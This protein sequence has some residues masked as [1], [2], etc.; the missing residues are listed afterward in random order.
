MVSRDL[1]RKIAQM[2][3]VGF[4]EAEVRGDTPVVRVM[5]DFGV[6]GVILYNIDLK[7]FVDA[8]KTNPDLNRIDGARMCPKNIRSPQQLKALTLDLQSFSAE[9]ILIA[10]DQEGGM[11]SR[12]SPAAGY[13]PRESHEELGKRDDLS[14]TSKIAAGIADDLAA[15]G[16]NLN[17]A[18]VVDLSINP[19]SPLFRNGRCF[20]SDP[21]VVFR[22]AMEF[23]LAHSQRGIRTCLKHFPGKGSAGKD[24]HFDLPDITSVYREEEL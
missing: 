2:I 24:T 1:K 20:G 16:I 4:P 10:A 3:M 18:P 21:D 15:G 7:C 11:V 14:F 9:P 23:I 13:P 17:L 8:Q 5:K 22:H 6:G 19:E 12:L